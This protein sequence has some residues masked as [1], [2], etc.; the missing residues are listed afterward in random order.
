MGKF[1]MSRLCAML[2]FLSVLL[3][4]NGHAEDAQLTIRAVLIDGQLGQKPVPRLAISV[5]PLD[6]VDASPVTVKTDFDGMVAVTVAAGT[7]RLE[8]ASP[9]AFEG[10]QFRWN[11]TVE[12]VGAMTIALSNDNAIV[13]SV[14]PEV[15]T[16]PVRVVD[17]LTALYTERRNSV[18]TVWS[19][20]G[21]GTGFLVDPAG[22]IVTNHHVVGGSQM[23]AVQFDE[24]RK[25]RATLLAGDAERDVAVLQIDPS[26]FSEATSAPLAVISGDDAGVIEGE[27]VFTI[28]SPLNQRKIVTSGVVSKVEARAII[29]DININH[30]NSGGPLF[31]SLG[32]VV[33]VTT[34]GDPD[35]SGPG[36]SGIVRLSQALP[37]IAEARAKVASAEKPP[38]NLLPVDPTDSYPLDAI[39]MVIKTPKFDQRPYSLSNGGFD[40]TFV[41]P[42][43]RYRLDFEKEMEAVKSKQR[44]NARSTAAVENTIQPLEHLRNWAEY[45]GAFRPVL[46]IEVRPQLREGFWS[47]FGRGLAASQGVY[48]GPANLAF[49]TDFYRMKLMCGAKEVEPIHPG[50]NPILLNE[51]NFSVR[52]K[53]ATYAGLYSYPPDA[54][55]PE[56]GVV[57]LKLFSEKAPNVPVTQILD[58]RTVKKIWDDFAPY[59]K[60][61]AAMQ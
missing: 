5:V 57:T 8:T 49:R 21:H 34:F 50:K 20:F 48:A 22:L 9:V 26:P 39:K 33:G 53:D 38:A 52:V 27:R 44:R 35:R 15:P 28:G 3:T 13:T 55:S 2:M 25:V 47:A 36:V 23:L 17:E 54:I 31:N 43:L 10:K 11:E 14:A 51:E 40:V 7:Y 42:V 6:V 41:T 4:S 29:S 37:V 58:V 1:S 19:E 45:V 60:Q 32:E 46:F 16:K 61:R 12:V 30:G 56:C 18:F 59:R 24:R